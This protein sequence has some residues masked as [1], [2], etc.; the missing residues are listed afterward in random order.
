MQR[1]PSGC[2]SLSQDEQSFA[3]LRVSS[4]DRR[5]E[6]GGGQIV[7]RMLFAEV[8]LAIVQSRKRQL[9]QNAVRNH[10]DPRC[11]DLLSKRCNQPAV[12]L[13]QTNW[14]WTANAREAPKP[15]DGVLQ[16][17]LAYR[18]LDDIE[19]IASYDEYQGFACGHIV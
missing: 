11:L 13:L 19:G 8:A 7:D 4:L 12:K 17:F 10:T 16:F 9:M 2:I 18:N 1:W 14:D 6:A 15:S 5:Q 3:G